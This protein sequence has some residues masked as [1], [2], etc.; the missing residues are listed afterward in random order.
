[1]GAVQMRSLSLSGV[2]ADEDFGH[3]PTISQSLRRGARALG[4]PGRAP[5]VGEK[6]RE[7]A[8]GGAISLAALEW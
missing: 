8:G 4:G 5:E 6:K 1:M 3:R 2:P 7:R